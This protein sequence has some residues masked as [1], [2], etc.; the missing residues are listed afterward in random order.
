[1]SAAHPA[2]L[3][4]PTSEEDVGN[5]EDSSPGSR[6]ALTEQWI[7]Y[8]AI[9]KRHAPIAHSSILCIRWCLPAGEH[10]AYDAR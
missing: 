7:C 5:V 1:L 3:D 6:W 9:R 10:R 2:E 4:R 8:W